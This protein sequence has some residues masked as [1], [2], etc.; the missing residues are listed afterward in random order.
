[1]GL[2]TPDGNFQRRLA[3]SNT[4]VYPRL[5]EYFNQPDE[6]VWFSADVPNIHISQP[7][8]ASGQI[9]INS[10]SRSAMACATPLRPVYFSPHPMQQSLHYDQPN[11]LTVSS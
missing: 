1:M 8:P 6:V 5:I 9:L 3:L 7:L 10:T 4:A 11:S 2:V